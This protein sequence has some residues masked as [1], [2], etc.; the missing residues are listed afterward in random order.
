MEITNE[1]A[2]S[3]SRH[4]IFHDCPR[5]LY[6]QYYGSWNGWDSEAPREARVAYRLKQLKNLSMLVGE[7]FH[8]ELSEILRRRGEHP[9]AVPVRQLK[10]DMERRLLARLRESRNADWDRYGDPKR[11]TILFEDYYQDGIGVQAQSEAMQQLQRCVEGFAN[12][13][14]GRRA[15]GVP[16]DRLVYIDPKDVGEKRVALGDIT[17]YA[18]PDL[19]VRGKSGGL[20]IVDWKTGKPGGPKVAQLAVY[21]IFVTEKFG[22]PLEQLTAHIVYVSAGEHTEQN[23]LEG[24]EEARRVISTYVDD[25]KG[26]LTDTTANVAGDIDRFPMTE[27]TQRCRSCNFRELCDRIEEPAL[28]PDDDEES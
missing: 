3:W 10:D 22:I 2:F 20:H 12:S 7:T 23:V 26:R 13:G 27:Q 25:V 14:F 16:K 18:S 19:V 9:Q 8:H 17:L 1:F 6:W 11:Y 28:T 5:K 4:K 21:G 24:V 15:F